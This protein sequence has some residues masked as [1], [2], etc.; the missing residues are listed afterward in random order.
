[1]SHRH[2]L[3]CALP[4]AIVLGLVFTAPAHAQF[5]IGKRIKSAAASAAGVSSGPGGKVETGRVAFDADVLEITEARLGQFLKGLDAEQQVIARMQSQD[6]ERIRKQNDAL[7]QSYDKAREDYERKSEVYERCAE[8][9]RKRGQADMQG[10]AAGA[11][12][13]ASVAKIGERMVAARNR[14]D[15]AEVQR[16]A[17]SVGRA[18][19]AMS[20]RAQAVAQGGNDRITQKCGA[21]PTEPERPT[22]APLLSASDARAAGLTASGFTDRQYAVMRERILPFVLSRGKNN[23]GAVY[24]E[25]EA[26]ALNAHLADLTK[27]TELFQR[28]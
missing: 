17:D 22:L 3:S 16:L 24:T 6:Q 26:A 28:Y 2:H 5:G 8:P 13:S 11:P 15:L 19:M 1:M 7:Q 10:V 12:D 27:Y 18:S 20:N 9:E 21:R 14:G 23:S 25:A 4:A